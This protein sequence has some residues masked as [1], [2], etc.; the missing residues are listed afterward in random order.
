MK[1]YLFLVVPLI[2]GISSA[3]AEVSILNDQ[4]YIASDDS[5]HIVG[6]IQNDLEVPLNQIDV[7]VT[8]YSGDEIV[9]TVQT[10]SLVNTIMPG[11]DRKSTRLN[12]SH[13][14]VSRMPSSA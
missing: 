7:H 14:S 13:S 10:H 3:W 12:S 4:H 9:D 8:L 5:L 6:E 11:I 1:K 2:F